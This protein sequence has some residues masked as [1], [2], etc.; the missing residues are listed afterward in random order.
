MDN[1]QVSTGYKLRRKTIDDNNRTTKMN[2][3]NEYKMEGFVVKD[4]SSEALLMVP[5]TEELRLII[6]DPLALAQIARLRQSARKLSLIYK[7]NI[8]NADTNIF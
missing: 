8:P 6:Q 7:H 3:E 1:I 5:T 4:T 2:E